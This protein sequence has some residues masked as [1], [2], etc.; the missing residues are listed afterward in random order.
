MGFKCLICHKDF[1][2]N[3][4]ALKAHLVSAHK[5]IGKTIADGFKSISKVADDEIDKRKKILE[6]NLTL[7]GWIS[8]EGEIFKCGTMEHMFVAC[9]IGEKEGFEPDGY[10]DMWERGYIR[11]YCNKHTPEPQITFDLDFSYNHA[12]Y[13]P[14]Q[15][16]IMAMGRLE[17]ALFN[18]ERKRWEIKK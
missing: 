15:K 12:K 7:N 3:Q 18:Q 17:K 10:G 9:E 6:S 14:T 13:Q 8:T 1:G 2:K 5:G 16:Q 11:F 4:S